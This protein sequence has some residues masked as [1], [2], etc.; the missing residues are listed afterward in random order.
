M[1]FT[2]PDKTSVTSGNR[3]EF[4]LR[5]EKVKLFLTN[6]GSDHPVHRLESR[7]EL[8]WIRNQC[9]DELDLSGWFIGKATGVGAVVAVVRSGE[10][11]GWSKGKE[12]GDKGKDGFHVV[13]VVA[14]WFPL[15]FRHRVSL[16]G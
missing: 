7:L 12:D 9:G 15:S 1:D 16:L 10:G 3:S 4:I 6:P 5:L 11:G 14:V 8:G 13:L 2:H